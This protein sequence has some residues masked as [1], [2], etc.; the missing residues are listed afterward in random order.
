MSSSTRRQHQQERDNQYTNNIEQQHEATIRS[1]DETKNNIHK[2][3]E[4]SR[5]ELPRYSQ[6]VTD[7][8]NEAADAS[9]EIADNFLESQKDVINSIQSTWYS[10]AERTHGGSGIGGAGGNFWTTGMMGKMMPF[11]SPDEMANIYART[12]GAVTEAYVASTRMVTNMMFAGM[13]TTRATTNYARQNTKEA[14]RITSNTARAFAQ[15]AKETVQVQGEERGSSAGGNNSFSA[16][17]AGSAASSFG[18]R[19]TD[20]T[21]T[22]GTLASEGTTVASHGETSFATTAGTASAT[23]ATA[24]SAEKPRKK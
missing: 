12:I 3:I 13:E 9:L 17:G 18:S 5:R 21:T 10:V 8:Q 23:E 20:T 15:N 6:I 7:F 16:G 1:I 19:G 4:E 22:T 2:S 24:G 14:T 11:F